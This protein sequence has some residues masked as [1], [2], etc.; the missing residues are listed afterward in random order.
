[1]FPPTQKARAVVYQQEMSSPGLPRIQRDV[2]EH[3]TGW[4]YQPY[5]SAE[6]IRRTRILAIPCYS[7]IQDLTAQNAQ[8]DEQSSASVQ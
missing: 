8:R 2:T 7:V 1:M 6:N 4:D 5:T 3:Q